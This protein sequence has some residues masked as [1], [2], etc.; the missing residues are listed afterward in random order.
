VQFDRM[1]WPAHCTTRTKILEGI[2]PPR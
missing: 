2:S 1:V